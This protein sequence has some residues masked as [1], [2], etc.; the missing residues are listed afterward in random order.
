[1]KKKIAGWLT[2]FLVLL[3]FN[4]SADGAASVS[5][6]NG[7]RIGVLTGT[8]MEGIAKETFPDSEYLYLNNYPDCITALLSNK[9]DAF[10]G[11]E[12]GLKTIH[13][14][15]PEVDFIKDRITSQ[16]YSFAFRKDDE[17]STALCE[18]LNA[19]LAKCHED[20]TMQELEDIWFGIDEDRKVVDMSGLTGENGTIRVITT[21]T[22]MPFSY[23]KDNKNVGYDIDLVVRFCKDRGYRLKLG[24][25]DFSGRIPA[26][27]SGKYDFTTDMNVTPEREEEVLFSDPTSTGGVVLAV[28]SEDLEE[29]DSGRETEG[30]DG[31]P[32]TSGEDTDTQFT[33]ISELNG[34]RIGI[35]TGSSFDA[36]V[37]EALPDAEFNYYNTNPDLAAALEADKID[38]FPGDDP[39]LRL[40]VSED[41][42]LTILDERLDSF[43]YGFIFPKTK[44][45]EE[46]L[47]K[48]NDWLAAL[49]ESGE[50]DRLITKWTDGKEEEK[51]IPDY[52]SLP[53]PE[54][55]LTLATEG[56][57]APM[58]YVKGKEL[59]GLDVDLAARFCEASGYGLQ[60]KVINL[61][62]TLQ[63]V[64]NGKVDFAAS[65]ITITEERAES[66]NFSDPYYEGGTAMCVLKKT[67]AKEPVKKRSR[68]FWESLKESFHKTF[69]REERWKLFVS[70]VGTT[71]LITILSILSGTLLGF[72]VFL[73]CRRGNSL[74]NAITRFC[75]WLVQGMPM[76]VLL[77]I[78]Y[79]V[80][81][82]KTPI[83]GVAVAVIGFTLTFGSAVF[84]LMK[85]GVGT[86]D[87]GQYEAAC[88]L[89]YSDRKTFFRIIL[90]QALPHIFPSYKSEVV[91]L[92]KA[93]AIV[94]Y[95]AVQ[96]LTKM[97]D[98][99][100]SRTYEA[101]F[102]LIAVTIIYFILEGLI[103]TLI[104]RV[105]TGYDPKG[106]KPSEIL[107]GV[108]T[109]D[110]D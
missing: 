74:A 54:G 84:G 86:V 58:N 41:D 16:D 100:R 7:K 24:D 25:V 27:T 83:S 55:M 82:G 68:S 37:K 19:F 95:I 81:F 96:D 43:E 93:T 101:F 48:F 59:A 49:K 3:T 6:Y 8:L 63:A 38:G 60:I 64:Q 92:I 105:S 14:E 32:G 98:I 42:R 76:V 33:S 39:V 15:Q 71:L 90:P 53:A 70:G 44:E 50:L 97:G 10:L 1:M 4:A 88:A 73:L 85:M 104:S 36:I 26:V 106:R 99:V 45:G 34:K 5:D 22:D 62:G 91:S 21:S 107:K 23:I 56:A 29:T 31:V 52:A 102:P 69:L 57:Y 11:D 103:R 51:T 13:A 9:I 87:P 2:L 20:G 80:I 109:D 94:G 28:K 108:K 12:P 77:M 66:V 46:L 30:G 65:G 72:L 18:E 79:Y 35:Q 67:A 110:K 89:G 40:M 47:G 61:D 17:E 78:L 75:M